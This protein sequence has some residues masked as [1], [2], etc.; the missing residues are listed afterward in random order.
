MHKLVLWWIFWCK[1]HKG[2]FSLL[3]ILWVVVTAY[4]A[5]D[6]KLTSDIRAALPNDQQFSELLKLIERPQGNELLYVAINNDD[7]DYPESLW[8]S[9]EDSIS[10]YIDGYFEFGSEDI[11]DPG[12]L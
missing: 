5:W 7:L 4:F 2:L 11:A 10:P 12:I 6:L 1:K 3:L 8:E 9:I